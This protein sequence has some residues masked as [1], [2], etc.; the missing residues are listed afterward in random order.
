MAL[1]GMSTTQFSIGENHY[2]RSKK[3]GGL[4]VS[5]DFIAYSLHSCSYLLLV[6]CLLVAWFTLKNTHF[7][8]ET[9]NK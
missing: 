6:S 9:S 4:V 2:S 5:S 8:Q 3:P 1:S 7:Q